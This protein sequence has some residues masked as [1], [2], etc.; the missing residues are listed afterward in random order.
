MIFREKS[1]PK[2][3]RRIHHYATTVWDIL[4]DLD[5][6]YVGKRERDH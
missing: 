1:V 2:K 6:N 5:E 4:F 3:K